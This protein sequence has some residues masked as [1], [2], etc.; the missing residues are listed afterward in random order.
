MIHKYINRILHWIII[1][2]WYAIKQNKLIL[3]DKLIHL[4]IKLVSQDGRD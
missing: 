2:G 4:L 3:S 1:N